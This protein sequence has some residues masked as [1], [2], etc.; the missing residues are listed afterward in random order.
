MFFSLHLSNAT[1]AWILQ[2]MSLTLEIILTIVTVLV[3]LA[4]GL[5]L[6]RQAVRR[7]HRTILDNWIIQ[8]LGVLLVLLPFII[9]VLVIPIIWHPSIIFSYWKTIQDQFIPKNINLP[10]LI[11]NI[12]LTILMVALGIGAARTIQALTLRGLN[13]NR[14]DVNTRTLI[15]R[16]FYIITL[17]LVVFWILS[18]WNISLGV[19]VAALSVVTV[20]ITFSIQDILK[21]LVCGFY[22]LIERP[23]HIGDQISTTSAVAVPYTGVVEDVRLRATLL[24]LISGEEVTI[25]NALVFGGVVVN[26]THFGERRSI[27]T[28]KLAEEEFVK[29]ETPQQILKTLQELEQVLVKPEPMV[30]L[31]GYNADKQAIVQVR[32][33]VPSRQLSTIS[34]VVYTLH[35]ILPHAELEVSEPLGNV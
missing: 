9:D 1:G 6:R 35:K 30:L 15:G 27:V 33:W 14:I 19:P 8:T 21:D 34:D 20:A 4:V 7:L 13:T 11:G 31:K 10:S 18:F 24:R 25:P 17:T 23:F 3:T 12:S 26:N 29:D 16:I 28:V 22:I 32:F 2:T 5:L